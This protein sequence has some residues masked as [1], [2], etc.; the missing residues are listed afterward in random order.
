MFWK[1]L[2]AELNNLRKA[3]KFRRELEA[4]RLPWYGWHAFR[5]G[6][7]S[8][9]YEIGSRDKFALIQNH[10]LPSKQTGLAQQSNVIPRNCRSA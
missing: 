5:Q 7:A 3:T 10:G 6:H 4:I 9:L 2:F 1:R 8:N